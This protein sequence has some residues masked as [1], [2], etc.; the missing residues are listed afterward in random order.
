MTKNRHE[1]NVSVQIIAHT[2]G[3][4]RPIALTI[5]YVKMQTTR[6]IELVF[7]DFRVERLTKVKL[8]AIERVSM[9]SDFSIMTA[10]RYFGQDL[11]QH[12]NRLNFLL[13]R[14]AR[15]RLVLLRAGL[16]AKRVYERTNA[17][18]LRLWPVAC[19]IQHAE[20]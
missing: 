10:E 1:Q 11:I 7:D 13:V 6:T 12:Q 20:K 19:A 9:K 14:R 15:A 18:H 17:R 2:I 5:V 16:F 3:L 8:G 4:G